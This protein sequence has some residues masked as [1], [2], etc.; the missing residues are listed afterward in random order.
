MPR[1]KAFKIW[2]QEHQSARKLFAVCRWARWLLRLETD[3]AQ[4]RRY[5]PEAWRKESLNFTLGWAYLQEQL[6]VHI[7]GKIVAVSQRLYEVYGPDWKPG[8]NDLTMQPME[9]DGF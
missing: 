7:H 1:R 5:D 8:L 9:I 2:P 4:G 3:L 6:P